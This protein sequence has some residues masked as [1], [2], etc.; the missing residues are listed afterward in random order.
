M[1]LFFKLTRFLTIVA[2]FGAL[3]ANAFSE[4]SDYIKL[5]KPLLSESG[6]LIKIF[7]Y[8]CPFCYKYD[9]TVTPK[10]LAKINSLKFIPFHLKTKGDYGEVASRVFAVLIVMDEAR[11]VSLLD[12]NSLF[13]KAKFAYY[14][15][16]HDKKERWSNGKDEAK[17]IKTG[18]EA[19]GVNEVD[20]QKE[21]S[22]PKVVELLKKWDESY[23]VAKIQ[24]VP[25]FVV[26]GKYLIKTSSITSIDQMV[27]LIEELLK[28]QD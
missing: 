21:L 8:S 2:L 15:A 19:A 26:N 27:T 12:D 20:Y 5:E 6:T 14:E 22:N 1:K 25:A 23:D 10:V 4:G 17:F 16:Y 24:G 28:K 3:N 9:K 11:G 7:S 18:L 13:K